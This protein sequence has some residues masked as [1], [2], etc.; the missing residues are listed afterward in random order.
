MSEYEGA[1]IIDDGHGWE[2]KWR[3]V[4]NSREMSECTAHGKDAGCGIK[5]FREG[6]NWV[7]GEVAPWV[8]QEHVKA[9]A[10]AMAARRS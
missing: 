7:I 4:T 1:V 5:K 3:D 6:D 2:T 8:D 9:H 10:K